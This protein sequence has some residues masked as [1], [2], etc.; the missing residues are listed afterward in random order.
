MLASHEPEY[1]LD[2]NATRL[3]TQNLG[4]DASRAAVVRVTA[5]DAPKSTE[6]VERRRAALRAWLTQIRSMPGVEAA[7]VV[8]AAPFGGTMYVDRF[9]VARAETELAQPMA[10]FVFAGDS[11][12]GAIGVSVLTGR[13]FDVG[14]TGPTARAALIDR[15]IAD[16]YLVGRNPIG[17]EIDVPTAEGARGR[18]TIVGVV[19]N[20]R[21]RDM[22]SIDDYGTIYLSEDIPYRLDA[23]PTDD[24]ELVIR[25]EASSALSELGLQQS[26][27]E[28]TPELRVSLFETMD[29]RLMRSMEKLIRSRDILLWLSTLLIVVTGAGVYSLFSS[30]V[31]NRTREFGIRLALGATTSSLFAGVMRHALSLAATSLF[32]SFP[33]SL[34][35]GR[36]TAESLGETWMMS[37]PIWIAGAA[38][39][40][41]AAAMA[42]TVPAIRAAQAQPS[43]CLRES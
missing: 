13:G 1:P 34:W 3:L 15:S 8:S 30:A 9:L 35:V 16:R 39:V 41:A 7:A 38:A 6:E 33:I 22:R 40:L 43:E 42:V 14:E 23:V 11:F 26:L 24:V 29:A 5:Y 32:V 19:S 17:A 2:A 10:N 21:Q 20:A 27:G 4:F 25:G 31:A 37:I 36:R 28:L 12:T 18:A